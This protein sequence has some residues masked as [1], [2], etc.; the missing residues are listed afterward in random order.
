[1]EAP[2]EDPV[3]RGVEGDGDE[4]DRFKIRDL[5]AGKRCSQAV[6]GFLAT[7]DGYD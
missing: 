1:M 7:T 6:V 3:G 4:Q 5:F 2:A